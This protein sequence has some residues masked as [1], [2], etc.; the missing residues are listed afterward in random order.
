[1]SNLRSMRRQS[2]ADHSKLSTGDQEVLAILRGELQD[3]AA[4]LDGADRSIILDLAHRCED[5]LTQIALEGGR[6]EARSYEIADEFAKI[7]HAKVDDLRRDFEAH[8]ARRAATMLR[9]AVA[10]S[11][12][13]LYRPVW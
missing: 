7:L 1:M 8:W 12:R 10:A 3:L 9:S 11:K 2:G 13:F 4:R 6:V 5:L